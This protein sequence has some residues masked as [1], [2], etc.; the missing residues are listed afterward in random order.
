MIG[1][2]KNNSDKN[3]SKTDGFFMIQYLLRK[4]IKNPKENSAVSNL[5][6]DKGCK[7]GH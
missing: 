2:N 3:I 6:N 4:C 5:E 7:V 1:I